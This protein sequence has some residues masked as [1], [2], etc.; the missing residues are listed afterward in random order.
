MGGYVYVDDNVRNNELKLRRV[1]RP[2]L[3]Y[4]TQSKYKW[5]C[6]NDGMDPNNIGII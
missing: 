3:L 6:I 2:N 4:P 5:L 1:F